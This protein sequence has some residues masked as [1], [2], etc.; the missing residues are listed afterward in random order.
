MVFYAHQITII[1]RFNEFYKPNIKIF[2]NGNLQLTGIKK[3]TDTE[4]IANY[5]INLIKYS[6]KNNKG[7]D[8]SE[9]NDNFI[10]KLNFCNFKIRM[11]NTDFKSYTNEDKTIKFNIRRKELHNLLISSKYNNK[12]S[13]QPGIYQGVK[14]EYY[15]NN[16]NSNGN[17]ICENHSYNKKNND[18]NCKKVTIAIFES[19]SILITGG[20]TFEQINSA[21]KYITNII[22]D[23][24]I[25]VNKPEINL[26]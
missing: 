1:Y 26:N 9:N 16:I 10:D 3:D 12:S 5:I 2:K 24:I 8:L 21:Y 11:I 15:F 4:I 22:S 19:G 6:Y 20:V 14:L 17:C 25:L 7:I 18:N 13:F 23:N